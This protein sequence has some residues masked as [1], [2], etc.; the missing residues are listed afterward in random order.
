MRS[1]ENQINLIFCSR[2]SLFLSFRT[3]CSGKRC[4]SPKQKRPVH[5]FP[6]QAGSVNNC[7]S[8]PPGVDGGDFAGLVRNRMRITIDRHINKRQV[9]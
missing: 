3:S 9:F 4:L 1:A 5:C 2:L 6:I 8:K 7:K